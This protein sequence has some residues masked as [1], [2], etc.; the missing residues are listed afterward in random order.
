MTRPLRRPEVAEQVARS[1]LA[2][3][4]GGDGEIKG[5]GPFGSTS[6]MVLVI[7]RDLVLSGGPALPYFLS[8]I[9]GLSGT[10]PF[11]SAHG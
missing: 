2:D 9:S 4:A 6:L 7:F 10:M 11:R 5:P 1:G 3:R 8:N